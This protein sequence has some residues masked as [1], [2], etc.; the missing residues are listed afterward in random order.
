MLFKLDPTPYA[1]EVQALEA[2]LLQLRV[3]LLT[4]RAN[5]RGLGQRLNAATGKQDAIDSK[6]AL[7]RKRLQ[8]Q[9][10]LASS[11]AGNRFDY[12]QAQADAASPEA[13]LASATASA[14]EVREKLAART[15]EGEQDE[16]ANVKAQIGA[17]GTLLAPIYQ[18]GALKTQVEIRTLEQKE[19]V[20]QYARLALR[21]LGDVEMALAA[22]QSLAGREGM[23]RQIMTEQQR[24]LELSQTRYR[25]GSDDRRSVQLQQLNVNSA[26]LALLRVQSEQLAQR[27]N[28][29]L[30]L[31]GRFETPPAGAT[32][33]ATEPAPLG[34]R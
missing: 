9:Q 8:Q 14:S 6:L 26:R 11:G 29:H 32:P 23:L 13:E 2:Q 24:A 1:L 28:L 33:A 25:I 19:A 15:P 21:A 20:A 3:Q 31:G 30:A 10:E 12:E 17:G 16:V 22:S 34:S 5:Q 7:T 4:A 27:T 18:G